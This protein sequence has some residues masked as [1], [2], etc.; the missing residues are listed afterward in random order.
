MKYRLNTLALAINAA[1]A[2]SLAA[3]GGGGSGEATTTAPDT[4]TPVVETPPPEPPA[5]VM[6][7]LSGAVMINQA[8]RNAVVCMDLNADG[9]CGTGEPA[10][11][12]TGA[13]GVYSLT[14]DASKVT[15][16]QAGAASLIAAMVPGPV[17][18]DSTTIDAAEPGVGNTAKPY[19]LRQV[20][21]RRGRSTR[22]RR[23]WPRAWP[24]A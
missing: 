20:P 19:V 3:C 8:I 10:S 18:A 17:T 5:P 15:A 21:A 23:W 4:A 14:Y 11:T 2:L 9:A 24:T 6:I 7:T 13:D 22:S 16:T 1:L 12:R